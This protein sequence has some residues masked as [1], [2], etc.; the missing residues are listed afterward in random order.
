ML[1]IAK[2][3]ILDSGDFLS[4]DQTAQQLGLLPSDVNK[5]KAE[6]QIFSIQ[7]AGCSLFP[8]YAFQANAGN[9]PVLGLKVILDVLKTTKNDWGIAFWFASI[10]GYLGSHRP[11]ELLCSSADKVL[12][13]AQEEVSGITHG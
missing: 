13:A 11:Q 3:A 8:K 10:N 7:H 4:L 5:W 2:E 9:Q 12:F 1:K 6:G